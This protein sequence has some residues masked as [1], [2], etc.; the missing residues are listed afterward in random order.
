M[1]TET[2]VLAGIDAAGRA[3]VT[4]ASLGADLRA[5]GLTEGATVIVHTSMSR[6]GWIAG[7]AQAVIGALLDPIGPRGTLVMPTHSGQLTDPA[8]WRAPPV[9]ESWW[10]TIR[11]ELPPYD[12]ART[13]TRSM[14]AVAESFRAYPGVRRSAHP[15]VSFAALGP[16]AD[17]IVGEHPL[18][19]MFGERSP[20]AR[21]YDVDAQVL[22]AGVGHGNNT[23]IHL[24]E[25]RANFPGKRTGTE[26]APM[27]VD[28]ERRWVRFE[29]ILPDDG[30]FAVLGE[31]FARETGEERRGALGW[32]EGRLMRVRAIVDYAEGWLA[33]HRSARAQPPGATPSTDPT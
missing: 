25:Y 28:G 24:G 31:D 20:L 33:R 12:P 11:E 10:E 9:P 27:L 7:G 8:G 17:S 32:G 22:L 14:G 6:L 2:E 29:E 3:P 13:P 26:G 5:I 19:S 1:T 16:A 15:H 30:D 4:R 23:A 18:G 21:L